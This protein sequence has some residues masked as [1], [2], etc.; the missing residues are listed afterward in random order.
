M[1]V[2]IVPVVLGCTGVVSS[3]CL[4]YLKKILGFTMKTV[5]PPRVCCADWDFTNFINNSHLPMKYHIRKNIG[6]SNIWRLV[7]NVRLARF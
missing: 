4:Q 2:I 7:E 1:P 6:R 5:L 3:Q